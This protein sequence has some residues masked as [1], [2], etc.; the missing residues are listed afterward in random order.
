MNKTVAT[1]NIGAFSVQAIGDYTGER[2]A[3]FTNDRSAGSNFQVSARVAVDVPIPSNP[4]V[5][6]ANLSL[7]VTN[8]TQEKG[9][10]SVAIIGPSDMYGTFPIPPRQWFLTLA[11]GM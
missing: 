11:L 1:L 9:Y 10:S 5:K 7:N 6:T 8:L 4:F 3:T 2:Y